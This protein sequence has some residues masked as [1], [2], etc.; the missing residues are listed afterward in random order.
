MALPRG[1]GQIT[2]TEPSLE[3]YLWDY[4]IQLTIDQMT[5]NKINRLGLKAAI[6]FARK[7]DIIVVR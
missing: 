4:H 6:E 7:G 5:G 1:E 3:L 2:L